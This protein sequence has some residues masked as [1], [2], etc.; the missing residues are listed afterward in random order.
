[1]RKSHAH[2][3]GCSTSCGHDGKDKLVCHTP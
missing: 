1:M 3:N 2:G